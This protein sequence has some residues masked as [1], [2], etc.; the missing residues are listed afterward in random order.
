MELYNFGCL[1][2]NQNTPVWSSADKS[3]L[4]LSHQAD[5]GARGHWS[6][7]FLLRTSQLHCACDFAIIDMYKRNETKQTNKKLFFNLIPVTV[8][9]CL[10]LK[11]KMKM[12]WFYTC[13]WENLIS[14][15]RP[16]NQKTIFCVY[17]WLCIN[18][19]ICARQ[20]NHLQYQWKP[21]ARPW[22][23]DIRA[24]L[25]YT[26]LPGGSTPHHLYPLVFGKKTTLK[27]LRTP[28]PRQP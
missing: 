1:P 19:S 26:C 6:G 3:F 9:P 14:T 12:A 21:S 16:N 2:S 18:Y 8:I 7:F 5:R 22:F 13:W 25:C 17:Y 20:V 11:F 23:K 10:R 15:C 4:L 24:H 27:T 28:G